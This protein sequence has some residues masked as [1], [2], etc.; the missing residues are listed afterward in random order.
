MYV[1]NIFFPNTDSSRMGKRFALKQK[2]LAISDI[3]I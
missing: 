1:Q 2:A 3:I